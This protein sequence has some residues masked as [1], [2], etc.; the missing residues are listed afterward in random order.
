M[1]SCR[2][3]ATTGG[4]QTSRGADNN[5][6]RQKDTHQAEDNIKDRH[7]FRLFPEG[8]LPQNFLPLNITLKHNMFAMIT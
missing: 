5:C 3:S 2:V 1:Q 4:P 7:D 8:Y 6:A